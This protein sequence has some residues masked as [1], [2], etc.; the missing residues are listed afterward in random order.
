MIRSYGGH[1]FIAHTPGEIPSSDARVIAGIVV[2]QGKRVVGQDGKP[3]AWCSRRVLDPETISTLQRQFAEIFAST[4]LW[5]ISASGFNEDGVIEEFVGYDARDL[6]GI[7]IIDGSYGKAEEES[8]R[9]GWHHA[10]PCIPG[11]YSHEGDEEC[12]VRYLGLAEKVD[13]HDLA[14][15]EIGFGRHSYGALLLVPVRTP[16]DVPKVLGWMG[17][18]N[19]RFEGEAISAVLRSWAERF[20]ATLTTIG[21]A[22]C[23][24]QVPRLPDDPEQ[25]R[26]ITAEHFSV[27]PDNLSDGRTVAAYIDTM[28]RTGSWE[29]WWD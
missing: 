5:P 16:A 26:R 20:G 21:F 14:A 24:L 9:L 4:G 29:F 10:A 22:R 19:Y 15:D 2:P 8:G 12:D 7:D 28:K 3:I 25:L 11:E 6:A 18:V 27:C 13:G 17:P 1:M 23:T